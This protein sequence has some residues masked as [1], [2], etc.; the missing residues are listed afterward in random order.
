MKDAVAVRDVFFRIGRFEMAGVTLSVRAGEY[1]VVTGPNGAGK[2]MLVRLLAGLSRPASGLIEIGGEPMTNRPPWRRPIG[3]VPQDGLLFPNRT[4][5]G[6]IRFG[7]EVRGTPRATMD[8]EVRRAAER[9]GVSHLLERTPGGLSGGERQKVCLARALV[10][11]PALL[12]L[13]EPVSAID[14]DTRDEL[15]RQLRTVQ[16]ELGVTALH[17]AHNRREIDLVADRVCTMR[18]GRVAGIADAPGP[19]A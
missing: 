14:E 3:Y 4:V 12:L 10:T 5:E 16:R 8:R 11:T 1:M 13:D 9:V 18:A 19:G 17:V 6:N 2:T 15:C 7:L